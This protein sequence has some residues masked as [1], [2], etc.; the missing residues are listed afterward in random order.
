MRQLKNKH[1]IHAHG[2]DI[3]DPLRSFEELLTHYEVQPEL[4][5]NIE[6]QG[7]KEPTGIQRQAI[8]IMMNVRT[9]CL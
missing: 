7:Y 3:P 9:N 4:L 8:P 2:T 6:S 5:R 1:H